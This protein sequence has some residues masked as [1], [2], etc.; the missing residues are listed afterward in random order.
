MHQNVPLPDKKS[1][2][3]LERGH[4]PL[5]RP[6]PPLRR[7]Y[8]LPRP[9]PPRRLRRVNSRTF[10]A[11]HSRS[12]SFTTQTL[13]GIL[14]LFYFILDDRICAINAAQEMIK[15]FYC[16]TY[17]I[18]MHMHNM[19]TST[20]LCIPLDSLCRQ[21]RRQ[22]APRNARCGDKDTACSR[23]GSQLTRSHSSH[24]HTSHS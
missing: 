12:F 18:L 8:P 24:L 7:G 19:L 5:P 23:P 21:R 10:G 9:N 17:L 16:S 6:L 4:G 2:N 22:A 15:L 13:N 20:N 11:R 3:F 14:V 1:K